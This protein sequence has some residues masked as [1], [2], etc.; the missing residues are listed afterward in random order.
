[1]RT[2]PRAVSATTPGRLLPCLLLALSAS[3]CFHYVPA[4]ELPRQGTPVRAHLDRPLPVELADIT[5]NNVTQVQGEFV[6]ADTERLVLS[7]FAVQTA[8]DV[9][10]FANGATVFLPRDAIQLLEERKLS[11]VRSALAA[12]AVVGA[13]Y[14]IQRGL[15]GSLG[16][17]EGGG[18]GG[19]PQ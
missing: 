7:A 1:V 11:P 14:L 17:G 4:P 3:G 16:G 19:P 12:V 2:T 6:S 18:G 8:S 10:H 9:E 13:G 15:R 5:A